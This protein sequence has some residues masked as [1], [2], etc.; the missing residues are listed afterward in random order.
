[1]VQAQSAQT[2]R[3]ELTFKRFI[4]NETRAFV[5]EPQADLYRVNLLG[6]MLNRY[7]VLREAGLGDVAASARVRREFH[8][9]AERML[10]LGFDAS[11]EDVGFDNSGWPVLTEDDAAKYISE[12][13]AYLH[14]LFHKI[15]PAI[16]GLFLDFGFNSNTGSGGHIAH[17]DGD[18]HSLFI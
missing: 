6:Q 8:D 14:R 3:A 9:I 15:I 10:E 11:E 12:S 13:D 1:M 18:H 16:A 4:L 7:D 2:E 5:H 17:V